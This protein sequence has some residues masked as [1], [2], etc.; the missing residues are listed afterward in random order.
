MLDNP[1][2]YFFRRL[3]F[4]HF[5]LA[6]IIFLFISSTSFAQD[7]L[8]A[9]NNSIALY[10]EGNT[11]KA[12]EEATTC[13]GLYKKQYDVDHNNY[14]AILRHLSILN[15]DLYQLE[16]GIIFAKT[17]V[18][19]WRNTISV[20]EIVYIDALDNLGVLYTANSQYDSA[21]IALQ[22]AVKLATG[23][24]T[25]DQLELGLKSGHLADALFGSGNFEQSELWFEK[26]LALLEQVE[27]LPAEY[28]SFC[29]S[30]GKVENSLKNYKKAVP[31]FETML[32]YYP[33]EYDNQPEVIDA[34]IELGKAKTELSLYSDGQAHLKEAR[35]RLSDEKSNPVYITA[36]KLLADNLERQG[37]HTEAEKLLKE[38]GAEV[39]KGSNQAALLM[40]NQATVLLNGG[41]YTG[42]VILFDSALLIIKN[43]EPVDYFTLA[44]ISYNTAIAYKSLENY[45]QAKKLF[46][47]AVESS[48]ATS[49][50][51][52][53]ARIAS[54]RIL[55]V[56]GNK[57]LANKILNESDFTKENEWRDT[58]R[59]SI[60]NELAGYYQ[61][62][63][64]FTK[65]EEYY[66]KALLAVPV[67][68]S[69]Q[70]YNNIAFNY[71]SLLQNN[72]NYTAAERL[73]ADI[74]SELKS[75]DPALQFI[76]LQNT[77]SLYHAKGDLTKAENQY[78]KALQ[79]ASATYGESS[80]QY[81][82]ILLRQATLAKD[83][84]AYD[85]AEPLF[86]QAL[87]LVD[88][89]SIGAAAIHNNMG[90][91][92]QLMGR[93]DEAEKQ[94]ESALAI[95]K[96]SGGGNQLD[97]ILTEENLATLY[98]LQGKNEKALELLSK[99]VAKNKEVF[100]SQ[101]PN[102]AVSLH[103]YASLL[104]KFKRLDEAKPLFEEALAIQK[105]S[106]GEIHPSYANTLHNL[107]VLAEDDKDYEL[108]SSLLNQ[109]IDIRNKLYDENHP[110]YT[111]A[112]F[113]RAVLKQQMND[114]DN[115]K[116][117]FDK[118]SELYLQQIIKY[119]P[120]LSESEKTAFYKK[121]TPVFNRYKEFL[122]EY[123]VNY[124]QDEQVL[125]Q[126]YNIQIA[127]K[128]ILLNSVNKTRDRI[129]SSGNSQLINDFNE[130]QTLKKQMVSYYTYSKNKLAEENINLEQFEI[131]VNEK[132]KQLSA[133]SELFA[134]EFD[135]KHI[136]W[137]DIQSKLDAEHIAIELIRIERN[138]NDELDSVTYIALAINPSFSNPK[139]VVYPD[140]KILENKY[141][142]GY[143]NSIQFKRLD[144]HSYDVFWH[145]LESLTNGFKTA[146]LSPD[147]VFNKINANSLFDVEN[148]V[149]LNQEQN[150]QYI[151]STRDLLKEH[152]S[153]PDNNALLI[154]D[155]YYP[156][157]IKLAATGN[158]QRSYNFGTI[159]HLP[160]TKV[161]VDYISNIMN[162]ESWEV[163]VLSD[164]DADKQTII[165]SSPKLL[166]IAVHGFF[167]T[168]N[169]S[170]QKEFLDNPL[171]R[172]GLLLSGA[173]S[174]DPTADNE[175]I[176]TA[177]EV[178]NMNLDQTDL[179]VLSAC[180]TALGDVQNGEGVY[181]LQRAFIV[182]GANTLIMS[183]W[184]V[185]DTATQK[186]MS[187]FYKFWL[188]GV[189]KHEALQKAQIEIQK[190]YEF[191]YYW[192]A[193]IMIGI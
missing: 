70:L 40:A 124:K 118:V 43:N 67:K 184:K 35:N 90:I 141:L 45:E 105:N 167:L 177:Y 4:S 186:L 97:Y 185:D 154:A 87:S 157:S 128:A 68:T 23:N 38:I 58:E 144:N 173:G 146:Y 22:E 164:K 191:P 117:D 155:P 147:G 79:I 2:A 110:S 113:S 60:Y 89:N 178:M 170:D 92:Y 94:F 123:Y 183:L 95:Y 6:G 130:W 27:E 69:A 140:G 11:E 21:I 49:V 126:L 153:N 47:Q 75:G 91:L 182:A 120:N 174:K 41:N 56:E 12:L 188:S 152:S 53:K 161:E 1:V 25:Y 115:A 31:Y 165:S 131:L 64:E 80:N 24:S 66:K 159:S 42:A 139:L 192:G 3:N 129:L 116:T 101:S 74:E 63:G 77:G 125:G 99:T 150:V 187:H 81:A 119:F 145:P 133:G 142:H 73:L 156:N 108:A 137:Q 181:G 88:N 14:R 39:D 19:S 176:L 172:S 111:A 10:N 8:T 30:Y 84:G 93:L 65:S 151:S 50:I 34:L 169:K 82:D 55:S 109:V 107:A 121:I 83:K 160:A 189:D 102:Y 5:F 46:W 158:V 13:E 98:S 61:N 29:Y 54:A 76:F 122:L 104:Q 193:F 57:T 136:L 44:N 143:N 166:H 86:K 62:E 168:A 112:L 15:Y 138:S 17:E 135:K 59:G 52:Q 114:F 148:N 175:G 7:W 132:E 180:E 28:L 127:T 18:A 9:Y 100:G 179:V 20:D 190:E 85:K 48:P 16:K 134:N 96:T 71:V 78:I 51:Q 103:N 163:K 26:S 32:D 33:P 106:F 149:Y 171:F 37:N 72:G 162:N 36:T